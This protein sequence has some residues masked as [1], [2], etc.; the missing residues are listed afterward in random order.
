MN[1]LL[2]ATALLTAL[3]APALAAY[4]KGESD[5]AVQHVGAMREGPCGIRDMLPAEP[6]VG[7]S[8]DPYWTPCNYSE[9]LGHRQLRLALWLR[10]D[11]ELALPGIAPRRPGVGSVQRKA[12]GQNQTTVYR[13]RDGDRRPQRSYS[14]LA[15][16]RSPP[17]CRCRRRWADQAS[18]NDHDLST[19]SPRAM[20][21]CFGGALDL[22]AKQHKEDASKAKVTCAVLLARAR[23]AGFGLA[24]KM[25]VE[26]KGIP[27]GELREARRG[28]TRQDLSLFTR[29]AR[30][31]GRLV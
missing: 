12:H 2:L 31:R 14:S 16:A 11:L 21:A 18:P 25:H 17:I 7:R 23:A 20:P 30:E 3:S 6:C 28:G 22:V 27:Q 26:D 4:P 19:S 5:V 24:V 13:H 10:W 29:N 1:K 8:S 15:T 9:R